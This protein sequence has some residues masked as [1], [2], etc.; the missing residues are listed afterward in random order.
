MPTTDRPVERAD[1]DKDA[2]IRQRNSIIT[3]AIE[4][5]KAKNARLRLLKE[6]HQNYLAERAEETDEE[7]L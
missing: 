4:K 2:Y 7:E 5:A 3:S 1:Q 6:R